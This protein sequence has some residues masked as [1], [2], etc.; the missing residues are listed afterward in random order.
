[1]T[2]RPDR[3][4]YF[5]YYHQYVGQVPDGD[6]VETLATQRDDV[7]SLLRS[8]SE[9]VGGHRCAEGKWS[10]KELIGHV[11]DTERMMGYRSL[12]FARGDKSPFPG[13]DQDQ[14]VA[15]GNFGGRTIADLAEEFESLRASHLTLFGSHG[16]GVWLRRG[17]AS[18]CEFTTRA[19]AWIMA[20]HVIHHVAILSERYL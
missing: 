7:V 3:T 15:G 17:T 2:E 11:N 9:D 1:M 19:V 8:L 10:V 6:I 16:E 5:E 12:A 14:Y 13:F 18:D 4:E 20:G